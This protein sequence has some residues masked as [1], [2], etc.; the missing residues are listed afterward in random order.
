MDW[1]GLRAWLLDRLRETSTWAGIL[2][3][4]AALTGITI[5]PEKSTAIL[6]AGTAA[7]TAF[8]ILFRDPPKQ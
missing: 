8:G 5:A 1:I 4:V 6:S 7:A 3:A 2:T